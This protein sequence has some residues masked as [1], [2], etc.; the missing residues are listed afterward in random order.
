[1]GGRG[2]PAPVPVPVS[3][4]VPVFVSEAEREGREDGWEGRR[5][6]K[7]AGSKGAMQRPRRNAG[8]ADQDMLRDR[9]GRGRG[10]RREGGREGGG[11]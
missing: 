9:G 4:P 10:E 11:D 6:R 2:V 3:V 5:D 1:M 8:R 7:A